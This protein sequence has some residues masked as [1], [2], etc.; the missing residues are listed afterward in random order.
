MWLWYLQ[1][2]A[3]SRWKKP[4][5]QT[6]PMKGNH[7]ALPDEAGKYSP[8]ILVVNHTITWNKL[9]IAELRNVHWQSARLLIRIECQLSVT[10]H[11][12]SGILLGK[13]KVTWNKLRIAE[14]RNVQWESARC[15]ITML[16]CPYA[17]SFSV[18]A[19]TIR[20]PGG[21]KNMKTF[22]SKNGVAVAYQTIM[23]S[24]RVYECVYFQSYIF[25]L[26]TTFYGWY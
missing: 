22:L 14:F 2:C 26:H 17:T 15:L 3:A 20:T 10:I 8:V 1:V 5:I 13:Y 25:R 19:N 6:G 12:F 11:C 7:E 21:N 24:C 16:T 18:A 9:R 23:V 4:E